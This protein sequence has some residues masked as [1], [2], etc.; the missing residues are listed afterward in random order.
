MSLFPGMRGYNRHIMQSVEGMNRTKGKIR[1][2]SL[3]LPDCLSWNKSSPALEQELI[4]LE[5]GSQ[6]FGLGLEI[7]A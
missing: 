5:S 1:E 2:S 4:P 7:T 3:S 6:A